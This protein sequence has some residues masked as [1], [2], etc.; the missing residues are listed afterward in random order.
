MRTKMMLAICAC[1]L[2]MTASVWAVPVAEYDPGYPGLRIDFTNDVYPG[3]G[4]NGYGYMTSKSGWGHDGW[5]GWAAATALGRME[6]TML[7]AGNNKTSMKED[8]DWIFSA[9]YSH[10][11]DMTSEFVIF[12]KHDDDG[13][14]EDRMYAVTQDPGSGTYGFVIGNASDGWDTVASGLVLAEWQDITIHYK[15]GLG[16]DYYWGA[17]LVATNQTT[18]HGRYDVDFMQIEWT[19]AGTDRW[20]AFKIGQVPEPATMILLGIGALG[21]VRR[22]KA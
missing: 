6:T 4:D 18:G 1:C 19:K 9:T 2:L 22:R 7:N 3:P 21:L 17:T 14:R 10:S 15:V 12:G 11:G 8:Q 16:L 13:S 20:R 5:A